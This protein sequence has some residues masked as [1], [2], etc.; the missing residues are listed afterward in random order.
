MAS[1]SEAT[2]QDSC[3][4]V[5]VYV[6]LMISFTLGYLDIYH[7]L[8]VVVVHITVYLNGTQQQNPVYRYI[9]HEMNLFM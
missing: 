7:I 6:V 2:E 9:R 5:L 4:L 8:I 1:Q 3:Y